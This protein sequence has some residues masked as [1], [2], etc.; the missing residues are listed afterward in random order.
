MGLGKSL[1]CAAL[2]H[3]LLNHPSLVLDPAQGAKSRL[4]RCV[5]LVVPTNVLSHWEEELDTWTGQLVPIRL[6]NLGAVCKEAR[7]HTINT[8][9]RRGGI[10]L[11]SSR[12]FVTLSKSGKYNAVSSLSKICCRQTMTVWLTNSDSIRSFA[13]KALQDPGPDIVVA[14]EGHLMLTKTSNETFKALSGIRTKRRIALTGSPIQNN[15]LEYFRTVSWA[16]PGVLGSSEA[17]FEKEYVDPIMMGMASDSSSMAVRNSNHASRKLYHLLSPYVH[18]K[19]AKVLRKDLLPMQQCVLHIRQSKIQMHLYRAFKAYQKASGENNFFK[20]Y[21]MTRT[22]TNHPGT[23]LMPGR[24]SER[25]ASL[26]DGRQRVACAPAAALKEPTP[27]EVIPEAA[28]PTGANKEHG[29]VET[30]SLL[31]DSEAEDELVDEKL[32]TTE[33][34]DESSCEVVLS[35]ADVTKE[36][37]SDSLVVEDVVGSGAAGSST[38]ADAVAGHVSPDGGKEWWRKTA[39]R[40]GNVE[41]LKDVENG[42]KVVLFLHILV[43]AQDLGDKVL[44]FSQCLKTLD[45]I[46]EVLNLDDWGKHVPSLVAS[47]PDAKFRAWRKNVDYLRIDGATQFTERGSLIAQ[48]NDKGCFEQ[49]RAT[50]DDDKTKLFLLSSKA[51]GIGVNLVAANRVSHVHCVWWVRRGSSEILTNL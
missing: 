32:E 24:E 30:I 35:T 41:K 11:V 18:R 38:G 26:D 6:Y 15:L 13:S 45:F 4:I 39:E 2:L 10:L 25:A 28:V 14:D 46:E 27:G 5:L 31:S 36:C 21:Q 49:A 12:T 23:L 20:C 44:V 47:F 17:K 37:P 40:N 33:S 43:Q 42:Y 16:R 51:G 22:L 7:A 29:S 50:A 19:D 3:A 8:W 48:F 1:T 9:S 34:S